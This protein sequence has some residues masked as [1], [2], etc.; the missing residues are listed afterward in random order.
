MTEDARKRRKD[1][2][3]SFVIG[4]P[5]LWHSIHLWGK[6]VKRQKEGSESWSG[7]KGSALKINFLIGVL[8]GSLVMGGQMLWTQGKKTKHDWKTKQC[9]IWATVR[10]ERNVHNQPLRPLFFCCRG[11]LVLPGIRG[12]GVVRVG[13]GASACGAERHRWAWGRGAGGRPRGAG[14]EPG[15]VSQPVGCQPGT[16]W[17][18]LKVQS[19]LHGLNKLCP[20]C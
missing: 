6:A 2:A 18:W 8:L 11:V 3:C 1:S 15:L 16:G 14:A 4:S 20:K 17:W 5:G 9:P 13:S 12:T 10:N 7:S 19:V